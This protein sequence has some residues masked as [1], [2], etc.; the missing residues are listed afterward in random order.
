MDSLS[1]APAFP[2]E[3]ERQ[4]FEI[5]ALLRPVGIP[6]LMLVAWRVKEWVEPLLYRII[7]LEWPPQLS[8]LPAITSKFLSSAMES[9]PS[10]FQPAI[11]HLMMTRVNTATLESVLSVCTGI[12]NLWTNYDLTEWK[13]LIE[14]LHLKHLYAYTL[15]ILR[16]LTPFHPFFSQITHL[17]L[18][19][20]LD[21]RDVEACSELYL[22]PQLTHLSFNDD[23]FLPLCGELLETSKGIWTHASNFGHM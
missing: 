20:A 12:D 18:I 21:A 14:P 8:M 4:I 5:A 6:K 16:T 1:T 11:R 3:L 2:P 10:F 7:V 13:L 19:D 9:R 23:A 15:P 22:I 17:E